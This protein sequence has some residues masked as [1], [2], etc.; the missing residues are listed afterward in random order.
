MERYYLHLDLSLKGN[1]K[2]V[3]YCLR[4]YKTFFIIKI[5]IKRD[6]DM[7]VIFFDNKK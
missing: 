3:L 2:S 6:F 7:K 1:I 4:L 5:M